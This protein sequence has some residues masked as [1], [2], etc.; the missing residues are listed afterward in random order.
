L[1]RLGVK[2]ARQGPA[3]VTWLLLTPDERIRR[4]QRE[5][6]GRVFR[7]HGLAVD[8]TGGEGGGAARELTVRSVE[9]EGVVETFVEM[10]H[11]GGFVRVVGAFALC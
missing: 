10:G 5:E 4:G 8:E 7:S 9:I 6:A 3:S 2:L 1:G 11:I